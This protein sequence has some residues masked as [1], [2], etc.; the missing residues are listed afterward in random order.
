MRLQKSEKKTAVKAKKVP[1]KFTKT[2]RL[3]KSDESK[4]N[5]QKDC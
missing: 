4:K 2:G 3:Q 1:K 5:R